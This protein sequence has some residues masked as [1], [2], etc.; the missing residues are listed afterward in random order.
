MQ[1]QQQVYIVDS[2]P[3][4]RGR[5]SIPDALWRPET[6]H[7]RVLLPWHFSQSMGGRGRQLAGFFL[8]LPCRR[9]VG[10]LSA[11]PSPRR[12]KADDRAQ[13]DPKIGVL[14]GG[15]GGWKPGLPHADQADRFTYQDR[16]R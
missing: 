9:G 11:S 8:E 13:R 1:S 15:G 14:G 6:R 7:G 12:V 4:R 2:D 16:V 10:A 3:E 5:R